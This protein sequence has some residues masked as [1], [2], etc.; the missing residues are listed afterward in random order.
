[1][2]T[3]F[4]IISMKMKTRSYTDTHKQRQPRV[5]HN[6][7]NTLM[8]QDNDDFHVYNIIWPQKSSI[9]LIRD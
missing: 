3:I 7:S 6:R 1:M 4:A 5:F 8:E 2:A 9:K